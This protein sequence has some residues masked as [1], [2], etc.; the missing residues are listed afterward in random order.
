[1]NRLRL[2]GLGLA[3]LAIVLDQISKPLLRDWLAGGD[4]QVTSFFN[5]VSA[6]NRGVGFSLLVM[7]GRSAPYILSAGALIIAAGMLVWLW[8]TER[9]LPAAALGLIIGGALGNVIDRL[10]YGAVFDFLD[11][12]LAGNHFPAFNVADSSLSVGV[13]LLIMDGLFDGSRKR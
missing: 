10:R 11:F 12:H 2:L 8:R 4:V 3:L 5:L 13:A 1:M 6:W 7:S 9:W